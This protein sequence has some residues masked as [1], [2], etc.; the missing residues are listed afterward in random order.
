MV[1]LRIIIRY[2]ASGEQSLMTFLFKRQARFQE[3]SGDLEETVLTPLMHLESE[4]KCLSFSQIKSGI[5]LAC[6]V[7]SRIWTLCGEKG[8]S[9]IIYSGI[10]YGGLPLGTTMHGKQ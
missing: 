8:S 6:D 7:Q 1:I 2:H 3:I 5:E 9:S 4:D 10:R